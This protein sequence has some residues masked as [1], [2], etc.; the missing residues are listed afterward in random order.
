MWARR[1]EEEGHGGF[2]GLRVGE[3]GEEK[4]GFGIIFV[5]GRKDSVHDGQVEILPIYY[6]SG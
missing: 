6:K 3:E 4:I 5:S 1:S 2:P